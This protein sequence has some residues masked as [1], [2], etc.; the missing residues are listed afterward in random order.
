MANCKISEQAKL[1]LGCWG[2]IRPNLNACGNPGWLLFRNNLVILWHWRNEYPCTHWCLLWLFLAEWRGCSRTQ[3]DRG[4]S[5]G[6]SVLLRVPSAPSSAGHLLTQTD[7]T[8]TLH[9]ECKL[10]TLRKMKIWAQP[11]SQKIHHK[12]VLFA[13]WLWE[14][15]RW[16]S[17]AGRVCSSQSSSREAPHAVLGSAELSFPHSVLNQCCWSWSSWPLTL[18]VC[19]STVT[20][21]S[22]AI[23]SSPSSGQVTGKGC[24]GLS[25]AVPAQFLLCHPSSANPPS[26]T[27]PWTH[28]MPHRSTNE[29]PGAQPQ[30]WMARLVIHPVDKWVC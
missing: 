28:Q 16:P 27:S 6:C 13:G 7:S 9:C 5:S 14:H 25:F 26:I 22:P 30:Q 18:C 10:Q 20:L 15:Q 24:V 8:L 3:W 23:S 1:F 19:H 17:Q 4:E 21:Q 11:W 29:F 2:S 12:A